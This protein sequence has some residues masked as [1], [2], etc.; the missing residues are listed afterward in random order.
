M[1][2]WL[3]WHETP[4]FEEDHHPQEVFGNGLDFSTQLHE[5][6]LAV[7]C[8]A[9]CRKVE[10]VSGL[11]MGYTPMLSRKDPYRVQCQTVGLQRYQSGDGKCRGPGL[12]AGVKQSQG[13]DVG[14]LPWEAPGGLAGIWKTAG[15]QCLS[16]TT[17]AA[18]LCKLQPCLVSQP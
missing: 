13:R 4:S 9:W 10:K 7:Q 3:G 18:G 16:A 11:D 14:K 6:P 2:L 12:R 15:S 5:G 17:V 1:H 8:Q